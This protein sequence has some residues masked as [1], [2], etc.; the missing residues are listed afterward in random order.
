MTSL[1]EARGIALHGR[2]E[3]TDLDCAQGELTAVIGTNGAGKTSLLRALAGI[4]SDE[5][6][7]IVDGESVEDAPPARRMRLLS[8]LPATRSLIWPIAAWDVISLGLPSPDD[9]RVEELIAQL[10]LGPLAGRPVNQLSTGERSRV[11]MARAL[12]ACPRLLLLDEPLSN[13]DQYWVLRTLEILRSATMDTRC[14]VLA[15]VHDLSQVS[16]FDRV[17]LVDDGKIVAD[18]DSKAV[19]NSSQLARAFRIEKAGQAWKISQRK[20]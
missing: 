18:G 5:G 16:A 3:Q 12:A 17:L 9:E 11:L 19:L 2:L 15:S 8:F 7:V 1:L 6:R 10:E 20:G 14:A 13:L 4:E